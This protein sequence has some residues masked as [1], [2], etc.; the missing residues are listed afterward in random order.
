MRIDPCDLFYS[1]QERE[2]WN[3]RRCDYKKKKDEQGQITCE[4]ADYKAFPKKGSI[5]SGPQSVGTVQVFA[6]IRSGICHFVSVAADHVQ[7]VYAHG[8][9]S[10]FKRYL[11]SE[12][13]DAEQR[14][15]CPEVHELLEIAE[16]YA[17]IVFKLC[18]HTDCSM[19][20]H[21]LWICQISVSVQGTAVSH[22]DTYYYSAQ[23]DYFSAV[24][25][26]VPFL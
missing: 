11:D 5:W 2:D 22:G 16:Q 15:Q 24:F 26:T 21:R 10:G 13:P 20:P 17:D 14:G 3:E 1:N 4:Q 8:A 12:V 25:C 7:G 23:P 6:D 9:V 19:L 18:G